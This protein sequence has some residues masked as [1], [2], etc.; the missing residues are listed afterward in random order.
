MSTKDA[1]KEPVFASRYDSEV[2]TR[3]ADPPR[4][5]HPHGIGKGHTSAK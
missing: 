2:P 5:S 4:P 3:L 1:A